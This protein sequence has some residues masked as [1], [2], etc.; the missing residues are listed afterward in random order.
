MEAELPLC[1][2]AG[3]QEEA[4]CAAPVF[5]AYHQCYGGLVRS[6][7]LHALYSFT[8]IH[9][10]CITS[11]CLPAPTLIINSNQFRFHQPMSDQFAHVWLLL[12]SIHVQPAY[13][14]SLW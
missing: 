2:P 9:R 7:S 10:C 4:V 12:L 14:G 8:L 6:S 5:N 3:E 11:A 1:A 13:N